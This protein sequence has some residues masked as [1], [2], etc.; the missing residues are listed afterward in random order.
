MHRTSEA[1]LREA[2]F[3]EA[4]FG[5]AQLGEVQLREAQLDLVRSRL[6]EV[7]SAMTGRTGQV[8]E[9]VSTCGELAA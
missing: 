3:G 8:T 1:Q 5:E 4:Q 2:Q 7:F 6:P 9:I